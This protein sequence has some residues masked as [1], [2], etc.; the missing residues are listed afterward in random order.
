MMSITPP[1]PNVIRANLNAP[2]ADS[3]FT[4]A[5][6]R[7]YNAVSRR[8]DD[9]GVSDTAHKGARDITA[10]DPNTNRRS[11]PFGAI[12]QAGSLREHYEAIEVFADLQPSNPGDSWG[13]QTSY[14]ADDQQGA[15]PTPGFRYQNEGF[16]Q[17]GED[18]SELNYSPTATTNPYRPRTVAAGYDPQRQCLT[19]VF[20]DGTYYNYFNVDSLTWK[21]FRSSYSPGKFI[22]AHLDHKPRGYADVSELPS[23]AREALYKITRTGQTVRQGVTGTQ[24]Y[25]SRRHKLAQKPSNPYSRGNLGGTGRA[26]AKRAS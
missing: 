13:D 16:A 21:N 20:R 3:K 4:A 6:M 25:G 10:P 5:Q 22:L 7:R 18:P 17:E 8:M 2:N 9:Y 12:P 15:Q 24:V 1:D 23:Y 26:R 14:F 11:S 19:V